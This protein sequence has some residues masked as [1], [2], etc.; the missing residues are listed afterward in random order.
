LRQDLPFHGCRAAPAASRLN[1]TAHIPPSHRVPRGI[2]LAMGKFA[3]LRRH[4]SG[5][6]SSVGPR[7]RRE[8]SNYLASGYA[9]EHKLL[10]A[11]GIPVRRHRSIMDAIAPRDG[12]PQLI[13]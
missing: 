11:S 4:P 7:A 3:T 8:V 9:A 6:N 1:V 2:L 12:P 10:Q 13:A 5:T